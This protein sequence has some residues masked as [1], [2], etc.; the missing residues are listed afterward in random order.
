MPRIHLPPP[1]APLVVYAE[2]N[3][4]ADSPGAAVQLALLWD[5]FY[6]AAQLSI[7][8]LPPELGLSYAAGV[9]TAT[10]DG[11]WIVNLGAEI[12][13]APGTVGSLL[14]SIPSYGYGPR[15]VIAAADNPSQWQ[16]ERIVVMQEGQSLRLLEST[17]DAA[18]VVDGYAAMDIVRIVR[19]VI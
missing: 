5:S 3:A 8:G 12:V 16:T 7:G 4:P 1:F 13:V 15:L 10:E 14:L 2:C 17:T 18:A 6:D 19:G 11:I 9:F